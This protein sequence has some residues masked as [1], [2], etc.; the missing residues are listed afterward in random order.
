MT[1]TKR[2]PF[3]TDE[4][5]FES[6]PPTNGLINEH[7]SMVIGI[8]LDDAKKNLPMSQL[9]KKAFHYLLKYIQGLGTPTDY[10]CCNDYVFID[11][12]TTY[13]ADLTGGRY[14]YFCLE[15]N[16]KPMLKFSSWH[17]NQGTIPPLFDGCRD[18]ELLPSEINNDL[19]YLSK[20]AAKWESE[21]VKGNRHTNNLLKKLSIE[22]IQEIKKG[23]DTRPEFAPNTFARGNRNYR[24][25]K[26]K[27]IL[28]SKYIYIMA[29]EILESSP[30]KDLVLNFCGLP[31]E[32]DEESL[33]HILTQHFSPIS[34][35]H[36]MST[37][38]FFY[39]EIFPRR[40]NIQIGEFFSQIENSGLFDPEIIRGKTEFKINFS[41]K[42]TP[43]R[44]WINQRTKSVKSLGNID[45]LAI[46][47]F[48]PIELP[49]EVKA[50]INENDL[51]FINKDL[52]LYKIKN[53]A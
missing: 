41:F 42:G 2:K 30:K 44:I 22:T 27:I 52:S 33:I 24:F 16:G 17:K 50:L 13:G 23:L 49:E 9:E 21:I 26:M 34:R 8:L 39:E 4:L 38:S 14:K 12:Y 11:L 19:E 15:Y 37:K 45:Y 36:K 29:K 7:I 10:E 28:Y 1:K 31:I 32:I 3:T 5:D 47:T 53:Q 25:E 46:G 20:E 48:H 40:M 18:R 51:H 43:Y 35:P 6:Y